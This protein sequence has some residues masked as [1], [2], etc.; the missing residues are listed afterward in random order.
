MLTVVIEVDDWPESTGTT[1]IV[2]RRA[3]S[4]RALRDSPWGRSEQAS[5]GVLPAACR[6]GPGPRSART[7][8]ATLTLDWADMPPVAHAQPQPR[9]ASASPSPLSHE[10]AIPAALE[11]A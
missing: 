11:A 10:G 2:R 3:H 9:T 5:A 8:A 1:S 6:A 4:A 7:R